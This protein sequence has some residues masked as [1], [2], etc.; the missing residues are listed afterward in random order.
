M[1]RVDYD[2][3]ADDYETCRRVHPKVVAELVKACNKG[4]D[5]K[6]LEVGCGTGSYIN[7]LHNRLSA[8]CMGVDPSD[9][10]LAKARSETSKKIRY[11]KMSAESLKVKAGSFDLV[12]SVDVIHHVEGTLDYFVAAFKALKDGGKVCTVTD[13]EAIIKTRTLARYF[14]DTIRVDMARYP[15]IG[16]LRVDM[17]AA[18]LTKAREK[19]VTMKYK[20]VDLAPYQAKA[21]SCLRLITGRAF[22]EGIARMEADLKSGP[23]KAESKYLMLWADK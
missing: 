18:G 14:P 9:Q 13:S 15:K 21:F 20:I 10:M 5:V 2:K 12:F 11:E 23:I 22:K 1:K 4:P 3:L 19:T 7:E 17:K 16:K 8:M 6:I